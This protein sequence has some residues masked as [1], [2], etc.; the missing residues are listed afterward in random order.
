M[1]HTK[2]HEVSFGQHLHW[3]LYKDTEYCIKILNTDTEHQ[4]YRT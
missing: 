2:E 4:V 3:T 1:D